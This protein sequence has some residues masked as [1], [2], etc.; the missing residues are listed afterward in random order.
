MQALKGSNGAQLLKRSNPKNNGF[1]LL[2]LIASLVLAG[3]LAVA[4]TTFII[5]AVDGFFLSKDAAEI[6]QKAQ[7]AMTR[8]RIELLEASR[9]TSI[10]SNQIIF[11]NKYGTQM[12]AR[13]AGTVRLNGHIL[14]NGLQDSHYEENDFVA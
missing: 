6:S 11:E 13:S 8:M 14:T 12:I 9:V 3:I 10:E 7:L 2:E 1:T 4:L 5:T